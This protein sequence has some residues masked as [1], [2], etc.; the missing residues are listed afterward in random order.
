MNNDTH[1]HTDEEEEET[2]KARALEAGSVP[3]EKKVRQKDLPNRKYPPF[4]LLTTCNE[5]M[6]PNYTFV[7][8]EI[9][10]IGFPVMST[11]GGS[12]YYYNGY[13]FTCRD[14]G[15]DQLLHHYQSKGTSC[16]K[17]LTLEGYD[18]FVETNN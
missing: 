12:G 16:L 13:L 17:R 8:P 10:K 14:E 3:R 11:R 9:W 2:E 4:D 7:V 15:K 6:G 18:K 5:C 1:K